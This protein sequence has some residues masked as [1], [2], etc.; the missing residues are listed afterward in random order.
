MNS[1]KYVTVIISTV[2]IFMA[3]VYSL[4]LLLPEIRYMDDE[5]PYW[6]QQRDYIS[7]KSNKQEVILLGDSRMK[8]GV[9]PTELGENAYNLSLGGA[10]PVE[11]FYTLKTY[12]DHHPLPK[13][14]IIGFAP[15]HYTQMYGS[16]IGRNMYFHYFN[17]ETIDAVNKIIFEKD[18]KDF[19]LERKLYKYRLPNVY[20]KP[21]IKS[22]FK[23]RST[24]NTKLY[25]LS[26]NEKGRMFSSS[27]N[28]ERKFVFTP[29]SNNTDFKPLNS[30]TYYIEEI[31]RLCQENA[32]PVY[33]EQLPMGNPGYQK[34][35]ENGYFT[36]YKVYLKALHDKFPMSVINYE[37][38]LY[39]AQLFR[40]NSHLNVKGAKRF[41][42]ELKEK[43]PQIFS[44]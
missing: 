42:R 11:M 33:V 26:R 2:L 17:D 3:T 21:V 14:V 23:P 44:N 31:L 15:T 28:T 13:A 6:I 22:I 25:E 9:L 10:S 7:T 19:S 1:K 32:I 8:M 35:L 29:E 27:D 36:E 40:D 5:Y 16:Y 41:S 43:Y 20:M 34:L 12:L 30:L 4:T 38:P 24:E 18:G 39:D 37:I